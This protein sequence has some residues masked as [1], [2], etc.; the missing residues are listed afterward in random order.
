[1]NSFQVYVAKRRHVPRRQGLVTRNRRRQVCVPRFVLS[2][3]I[4]AFVEKILSR[5]SRRRRVRPRKLRGKLESS[6]GGG[7]GRGRKKAARYSRLS[8]Y[9]AYVRVTGELSEKREKKKGRRIPKEK[10][11]GD[12]GG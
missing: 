3:R 10:N 7:G 2:S 12:H 5:G 1:M 8:G 6:G 9:R 4:Y 11:V